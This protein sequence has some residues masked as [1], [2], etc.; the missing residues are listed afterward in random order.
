MYVQ[1]AFMIDEFKRGWGSIDPVDKISVRR[2]INMCNAHSQL[3][4]ST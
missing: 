3:G 4:K 1:H 2:F